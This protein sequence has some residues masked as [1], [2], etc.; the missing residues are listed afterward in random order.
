[1]LLRLSIQNY[2]LIN[3]LEVNFNTGF[4]IITGETGAGKSILLGA[5]GLILG[6]RADTQALL[7]KS[8][9]CIIEGEFAIADYRLKDFFYENELDYEIRTTIRREISPEGKSR[10]FVNDTPVKLDVLKDLG[11]RLV[12]IHSQHETLTLSNSSFQLSVVDAFAGNETTV[13]AYKTLFR[14]Y[15]KVCSKLSELMETEKKS[16]ADEDYFRFQFNELAE[17][18]LLTGEK[19]NLEQE[20]KILNNAEEIKSALDS[21]ANAIS[22]GEENLLQQLSSV[23][24]SLSSVAKFNSKIGEIIVRIKSA[25]VEL[26]DISAEL[27][28]M[29]EEIV[30]NP[31]RIEIIEERLNLIYQFEQK[32]RVSSVEELIR[33]MGEFSEKLLGIE[34]LDDDIRKFEEEAAK[35][36]TEL[37]GLA[38]VL[39]KNRNEAAMKIEKEI[40]KLLAETGM[41]NAVLKIEIE[42]TDKEELNS[43]GYDTVRFLFSANKG[44]GYAELNKVASGGELSRL[45]L[46]IKSV[47]AKL[48]ALP[49]II[50]DE[51][52]TGI[53]GEVAFKVGN[54]IR[55]ISTAHQ[56]VAI[57]HLPQMA[58]KGDEHYL[59]YK[60]TLKNSTVTHLKKLNEEE[61]I[62]EIA[63][64]LSGNKPSEVAI[65]NARE[66]LAK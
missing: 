36:K 15:N 22:S 9:K 37:S 19:E 63:K 1:M 45:M 49:T 33:L 28:N 65:E 25:F 29:Q 38:G 47:I 26:K 30:F 39:S 46:C 11:V 14:D 42:K 34:K 21:A 40:K 41:P 57:T 59:V 48:T 24:S 62:T 54:I 27:E 66:L 6:N 3:E 7:D 4:T 10:A 18:K 64:M 53:S 16:K 12:D 61:R 8:K 31:E 56:V 32:H 50:F 58:G 35:I 17:A 60:E 2:V 55:K 23:S 5:L 20:L 13:T 51:I 44:I 52:D 43:N